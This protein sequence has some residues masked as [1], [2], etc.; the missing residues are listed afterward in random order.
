MIS[1]GVINF[2]NSRVKYITLH[3]IDVSD[4]GERV[5][6]SDRGDGKLHIFNA[7]DGSRIQ[8]IKLSDNA[9]AAGIKYAN[10]KMFITYQ[11]LDQV[12]II[13]LNTN[14]ID[15]I[16][17]NYLPI[18]CISYTSIMDCNMVTGCE[19]MDMGSMSH[20]M[21]SVDVCLG[22]DE[23]Q[24]ISVDGC[25]WTMNMCMEYGGMMDMGNNTPHFI[26]I[27]TMNHYWFV[28]TITSGFVG[29]YSLYT[30]ELIDKIEVGDSPALMV[31]NEYDKK[32]YVSRMM[33]MAGMMTGAISTII[34]EIDYTDSNHM[35]LSKQFE[36]SSP[37]PHGLAINLDGSEIY[38]TSNTADW[39]WK[40]NPSSSDIIGFVMD[41]MIGNTH[42]IETQRLKP[43]QCLSV[44]DSLLF[45]TCSAGLWYDPLSGEQDTIPGQ[46]QLWNTHTMSLIDTLQFTWKAKPWHIVQA[47][48]KDLIYLT[49]A[50]DNLYLGSSGIVCLSYENN[51]LEIVWTAH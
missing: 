43:I 46:V 40:I 25:D 31:L 34:Q 3:G 16:D 4:D 41:E 10:D 1:C 48:V 32:L 6:V 14:N 18:S 2:D 24:C 12:G 33:P 35:V 17:I 36:L 37:A 13:D 29:R 21:N 5:F 30:N 42:D 45:V 28:T 39:I 51:N 38:T 7:N 8:S 22:L 20:C 15:I 11:A 23:E 27:D 26:V 50:G 19:W 44:G 47:P 9:M 49:L